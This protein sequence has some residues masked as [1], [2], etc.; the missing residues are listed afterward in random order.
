MKKTSRNLTV[1]LLGMILLAMTMIPAAALGATKIKLGSSI[2]YDAGVST[3][4]WT[5]S[6]DAPSYV[7][8]LYQM[9]GNGSAEQGTYSL[10]L[11]TRKSVQT[12][13]L[14][15]GYSY[16]IFVVDSRGQ[17]LAKKD[18]KLPKA[19]T[20]RDGK[21]KNTS[22]KI[23][24]EFRHQEKN[25]K[26]KKLKSLSAKDIMNEL[27]KGETAY[28]LKYTMKM[29]TLSKARTFLI[30]LA[31]EA[32]NGFVVV[33]RMTNYTFERVN[34]GYE[35]VWFELAGNRF[36]KQL[37]DENGTIPKGK[38]KAMLFWDGQWVNT[39]EFSVK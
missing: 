8:V 18:Y 22:V 5:I 13:M 35:T 17:I 21:L 36:F 25:G 7:Y 23:S 28:G 37:Y 38:Y 16:T 24:T 6:G 26:Y 11:T 10:G 9:I 1:C 2:D 32:P 29:P 30:T 31:F 34:R 4:K 27:K 14:L 39:T 20:F 19:S 15:P 3:I 33:D 12:E